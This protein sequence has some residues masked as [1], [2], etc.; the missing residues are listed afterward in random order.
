MDR[1]SAYKLI[2]ECEKELTSYY[3]AIDERAYQNQHKVLMAFKDANV[4]L[5]DMACSSGYGYEDLGKPKLSKVFANI[6]K[7]EDAIVAPQI[8]CGTHAITLPLFGI[9]RPGDTMLAITGQVY[10]TLQS[11]LTGTGNGSLKDFG[12]TYEYIDMQGNDIDQAKVISEVKNKK[13]KMV[14]IQRSRGYSS[15]EALSIESIEQI[16]KKV[17]QINS[18][19]IV[20]VDNCY[21]EFTDTKEPIEVGAD[22][23]AGSLIKNPGG[24]IA[25]TGGYVAGKSELVALAASRLTVPGLGIE[26]GSYNASYYPFFEGIFVAPHV[27]ANALKGSLLLGL[28]FNKLSIKSTPTLQT[29]TSEIKIPSDIVRSIYF[30]DQDKL[31]SFCQLVQSLSP[32]DANAV[33]M[34]WDMP[35]YDDKVIMA[36]GTFVQGASIELSCD[37]PIRPPYIC[38]IQGG[39]TYEHSKIVATEA[40]IKLG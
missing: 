31:I 27:V 40:L 35:G 39:I 3:N 28:A 36:A 30:D 15:R 37:G 33:P 22:I 6:F 7:A 11:V 1:N 25:P 38:Y 17:K 19:I 14:Y 4:N 5:C 24:G 20:M 16:I 2:A 23:I 13:P 12:I 34:P 26:V 29:T 9:L 10:D 32:I 21:G 8:T 18:N